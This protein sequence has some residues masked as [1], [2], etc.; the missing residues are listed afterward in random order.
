MAAEAARRAKDGAGYMALRAAAQGMRADQPN[1]SR[2]AVMDLLCR[3]GHYGDWLDRPAG[4]AYWAR[5]APASRVAALRAAAVPALLIGGFYDSH[6]PGTLAAW[7]A[8]QDAA[9]CTLVVGPWAHFPWQRRLGDVDF[10]AAAESDIDARQIAFFDHAL[11]GGPAPDWAPVRLFDMG[12]CRWRDLPSLPG[13]NRDVWTGGTGRATCAMGRC[14]GRQAR[15]GWI[16]CRMIRG[17]RRRR[18]AGVWARRRARWTAPRSM[19][20]RRC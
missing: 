3:Y 18:A 9:P 6:L 13:P 8:L 7:E 16:I 19:R 4:D 20:G 10:G 1:P 2:P 17:A 15:R 5:I 12:V 14:A 11:K